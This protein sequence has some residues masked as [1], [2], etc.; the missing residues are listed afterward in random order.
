MKPRADL[1]LLVRVHRQ[2]AAARRSPRLTVTVYDPLNA[3]ICPRQLPD[4]DDDYSPAG[5]DATDP[6]TR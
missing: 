6:E 2:L 3:T 4:R 5:M 1:D